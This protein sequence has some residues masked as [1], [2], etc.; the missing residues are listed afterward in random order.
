MYTSTCVYIYIYI[1]IYIQAPGVDPGACKDVCIFI[2]FVFLLLLFRCSVDCYYYYYH[3]YYYL[4]IVIVIVIYL[5]CPGHDQG[6]CERRESLRRCLCIMLR[7]V[8]LLCFCCSVFVRCYLYVMPWRRSR[9]LRKTR[10]LAKYDCGCVF[11][12]M[13]R[14]PAACTCTPPKNTT[15]RLVS[16]SLSIYIYIY[17]YIYILF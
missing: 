2:V 7:V 13:P 6:A 1:Y 3:Y 16:L 5:L 9:H 12:T 11:L 8:L 4:V 14:C 10:E 15:C 17:V